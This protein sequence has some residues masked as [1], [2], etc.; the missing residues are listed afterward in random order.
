MQIKNFSG[1]G[2]SLQKFLKPTWKP[3]VIYTNNSLEFGNACEELSWN[4]RTHGIA[5]RAVRRIEEETS[6]VLLLSGLEE[7]MLGRF[8]GMLSPSPKCSRLCNGMCTAKRFHVDNEEQTCRVGCIDEPDCLSHYNRF[9]LLSDIFVTIWRNAGVHL[10]GDRLFHELVTEILPRS[11]RHQIV[12]MGIIDAIV[13]AHNY[14]RHN[15]DNAGEFGDCMEGRIRLLTAITP[16]Y[17]HAYQTLCLTRRPYDIPCQRF[18]LPSAKAKHL[19]HPNNRT[20]MREK[21]TTLRDGRFH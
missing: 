14:H 15:L 4:H 17:A 13:N 9:S 19:N 18:R 12:V 1:N 20:T 2:K 16:S 7:K 21:A 6:A 11:L 8:S 3:K 10:R 5:E